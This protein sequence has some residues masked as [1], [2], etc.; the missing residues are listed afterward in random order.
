MPPH[1][2]PAPGLR[3]NDLAQPAW[4]AALHAARILR[5]CNPNDAEDRARFRVAR[6][7]LVELLPEGA[8]ASDIIGQAVRFYALNDVAAMVAALPEQAVV[9]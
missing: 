8:D 3:L 7:R 2:S 1:H 4:A 6:N 5:E 9:A